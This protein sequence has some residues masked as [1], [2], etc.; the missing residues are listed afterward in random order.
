MQLQTIDPEQG[1]GRKYEHRC[2]ASL[3][4]LL[5]TKLSDPDKV[6][7][8]DTSTGAFAKTFLTN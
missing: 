7:E 4:N 5:S 8:S 1:Y 3:A 6:P 2:H